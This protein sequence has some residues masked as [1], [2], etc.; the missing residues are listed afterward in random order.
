MPYYVIT[1]P[2]LTQG[3]FETWDECQIAKNGVK[4]VKY[5]KVETREEAES[6]LSGE[7]VTFPPGLHVFTDG[8]DRGGVGVVVAWM[9]DDPTKE[10]VVV[11]EIRTSVGHIFYDGMI[12][13]LGNPDEISL[14]LEES[15]NVLAEL[16]GL[17]LALWQAP[18]GATLTI[19]HDY[20]GVAKFF[21]GT[22]KTRGATLTGIVEA[23]KALEIQKQLVLSFMWQRGHTSHWAGRHDLAKLNN[24]ADALATEAS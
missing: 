17:Y 6:M 23:C 13:S 19:V 10:P 14:A 1:A 18:T 20:E 12:P 9:G 21:D 8:N 2:E 7:G 11:T 4:G 5:Q 22:W 16:A 24:R 15:R 3:I